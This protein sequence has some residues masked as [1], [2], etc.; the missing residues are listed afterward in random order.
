M[1]L[2]HNP[3]D[4]LF[5]GFHR[6][7][8]QGHHIPGRCC[9]YHVPVCNLEIKGPKY[10]VVAYFQGMSYIWKM[11]TILELCVLYSIKTFFDKTWIYLQKPRMPMPHVAGLHESRVVGSLRHLEMYHV[12]SSIMAVGWEVKGFI[13]TIGFPLNKAVFIRP[14]FPG[15]GSLG[16]L[17]SHDRSKS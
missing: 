8:C 7:K 5:V 2:L 9:S 6:M 1:I 14:L 13:V 4:L 16:G 15:G 10:P 17:T 3:D 11:S 12:M